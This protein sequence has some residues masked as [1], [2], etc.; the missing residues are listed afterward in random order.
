MIRIFCRVFWSTANQFVKGSA[1]QQ[2]GF[3]LIAPLF[4]RSLNLVAT[5]ERQSASEQ[6]DQN[7]Y[8]HD[9]AEAPTIVM[10]WRAK[11]ETTSAEK[12]NENY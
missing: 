12:K 9:Q 7:N 6:N 10:E 3:F 1:L 4:A 5:A 2:A 8:H 11:I